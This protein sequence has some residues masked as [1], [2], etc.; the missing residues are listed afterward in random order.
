MTDFKWTSNCLLMEICEE[1]T[2]H[3]AG[4]NCVSA[5]THQSKESFVNVMNSN[6]NL[7]NTFLHPFDNDTF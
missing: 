5:V 2:P 3:L 6:K 1:N 7:L 4:V